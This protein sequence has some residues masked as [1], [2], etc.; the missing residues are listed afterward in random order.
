MTVTCQESYIW[1]RLGCELIPFTTAMK[2]LE[3]T[4]DSGLNTSFNLQT[5]F[6][7]QYNDSPE[8]A[9]FLDFADRFLNQ[10]GATLNTADS[11]V[12][13]STQ[14]LTTRAAQM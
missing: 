14:L 4:P 8:H 6:V 13:L 10:G 1:C 7:P 12:L 11:A 2:L 9:S 5:L 3:A